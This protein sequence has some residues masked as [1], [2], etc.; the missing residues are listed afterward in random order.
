TKGVVG[1]DMTRLLIGSEG[2]LAVV[3]Q[4]TLKLAPVPEARRLLRVGRF[5]APPP[6]NRP[7]CWFYIFFWEVE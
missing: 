2:T 6:E 4:A 1:Y 5:T 7:H 3:T